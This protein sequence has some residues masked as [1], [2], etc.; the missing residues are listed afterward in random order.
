MTTPLQPAVVLVADRTLSADYRVLFEGIFATMQTT[1]VPSLMMKH[2]VS[3]RVGVD[4]GGRASAAPLGI[5]RLEAALLAA[6]F[7]EKDVVCATP[8]SVGRLLGPWTKLVAVSSSDFL[9]RGMSNT[10]THSFWAGRLYTEFWMD[11]MMA[12]V[13]QAKGQ[14]KFQVIAGGAGSWQLTNDPARA[15][16]LG[17]DCIFEGYFEGQGVDLVRQAI[18]GKSLPG[19][20]T[21]RDSCCERVSPIAGPSVL[22]VIELSRGCG[23]GCRF[24]TMGLRRMEHLPSELILADL[25]TNVRGGQRSI[26]SSSEDFFRYGSSGGKVN[27][28]VLRQLLEGMKQI[29]GASF[30][31]IDHAN[32][33]SV[34]QLSLEELCEIRRLLQWQASTDHLWVN[35][36]LESANGLLVQANGPGKMSPFRAEDWEEMIKDVASK[37]QNAGFYGVYSVI[38]GLPGETVGD[39][40]RTHGLVKWLSTRRA[41]IFPVFYEPPV[42]TADEVGTPFRVASMRREH[43]DLYVECYELNFRRVPGLF[44]DNQRAGGV[45]WFKRSIVQALGKIEVRGWRKNFVRVGRSIASRDGSHPENK[46]Q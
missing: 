37:L 31:Q 30:M 9:G 7:S 29:P 3:P 10:T 33:S 45:S 39:V 43:L 11:R 38:L 19:S 27:F 15:A 23:K 28:E 5:R 35:L 6:G 2:F 42:Q 1:Q 13:R 26:V 40:R 8:E 34:A 18:D 25:A 12:K 16:E 22:G 17:F 20:V 41:V 32:V 4:S 21:E 14:H 46:K 44:W 36:G 24:C